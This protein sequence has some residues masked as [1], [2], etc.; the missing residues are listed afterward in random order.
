MHPPLAAV[1][2]HKLAAQPGGPGHRAVIGPSLGLARLG[3]V[4]KG[5]GAHQLCKQLQGLQVTSMGCST[6]QTGHQGV[7][8]SIS[9]LGGGWRHPE[10]MPFPGVLSTPSTPAREQSPEREATI[11]LCAHQ[12][13]DQG[14][15]P[16][17][18]DP[19]VGLSPPL[20]RT[21]GHNLHKEPIW[22][23]TGRGARPSPQERTLPCR[24]TMSPPPAPGLWWAV[25]ELPK[26]PEGQ[27]SQYRPLQVAPHLA[28]RLS[29]PRPAP[30]LGLIAGCGGLYPGH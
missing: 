16:A 9:L 3:L 14:L 19:F 15:P 6:G 13:C 18:C 29:G 5:L 7:S 25:Q 26:M 28:Q 23:S 20:S 1:R 27:G 30:T 24:S 22:L 4:P 8:N 17:L 2:P 12:L 21:Q 10:T 11:W